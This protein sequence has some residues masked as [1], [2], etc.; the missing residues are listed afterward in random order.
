[1][2]GLVLRYFLRYGG[3]LLPYDEK[4]PRLTWAGAAHVEKAVIVGTPNAGSLKMVDRLVEGIPGNA[5]HPTYG[6]VLVGTFPSGYQLLPRGR[7]NP[8][9]AGNAPVDLLDPDFWLARDWGLTASW[10][11]TERARQLPGVDSPTERL[12]IA[13]DQLRKCLRGASLFQQAMDGPVENPPPHLEYHLFAGQGQKTPRR[14]GGKRGDRAV[15]FTDFAQ[16]D[17]TV[18]ATSARMLESDG[19]SP[20]PWHTVTALKSSHMDMLKDPKLLLAILELLAT[21]RRARV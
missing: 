17:G 10:L 4:P 16:G 1:M 14:F 2:G 18:L 20:I 5:L 13:E 6:P 3:Q 11:D 12:A 15:S 7:H 9:E 8:C 21:D 19:H